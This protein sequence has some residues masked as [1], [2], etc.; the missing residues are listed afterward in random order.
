MYLCTC[1]CGTKKKVSD[2]VE[3]VTGGCGQPCTVLGADSSPQQEQVLF[4]A[5]PQPSFLLG[6]FVCMYVGGWVGCQCVHVSH[7]CPTTK[8]RH[9]LL[10]FLGSKLMFSRR[11]ESAFEQLIHL[12]SPV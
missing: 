9:Q 8:R 4:A 7:G 6:L 10:L 1:V 2:P 5:E 12:L 11:I 3:L